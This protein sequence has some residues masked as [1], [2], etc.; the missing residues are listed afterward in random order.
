MFRLC[1]SMRVMLRSI[2]VVWTSK[3]RRSNT[4]SCTKV[5]CNRWM[6]K[7]TGTPHRGRRRGS[8]MGS[9][10]YLFSWSNGSS[11]LPRLLRKPRL[12]RL[13]WLLCVVVV[14]TARPEAPGSAESG[15]GPHSGF[16]KPAAVRVA[17]VEI[18]GNG[19]TEGELS[20]PLEPPSSSSCMPPYLRAWLVKDFTL[21][22][23]SGRSSACHKLRAPELFRCVL[24][25]SPCARMSEISTAL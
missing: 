9:S 17:T 19:T 8:P 12:K 14:A 11:K 18:G 24:N 3:V 6:S 10:T 1:T 13:P 15:L 7:R 2:R 4:Q 5:K 25:F 22:S 23:S 21:T 20:P 16:Q